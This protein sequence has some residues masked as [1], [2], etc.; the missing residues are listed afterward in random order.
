MTGEFEHVRSAFW[1]SLP[2]RL[3][4]RT[5][6]VAQSAWRSSFFHAKSKPVVRAM[7]AMPLAQRIQSAAVVV[8]VAAALQPLLMWM[9][10]AASRPAMPITVFIGVVLIAAFVASQAGQLARFL[11]PDR[12][13]SNVG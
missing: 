3:L 11:S 7:S 4:L 12:P 5:G 6:S 9:M 2:A 1:S 13:P 8:A 10:P